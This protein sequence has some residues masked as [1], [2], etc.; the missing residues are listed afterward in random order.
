MLPKNIIRILAVVFILLLITGCSNIHQVNVSDKTAEEALK[1]AKE[2]EGS[3]YKWGGRG[4]NKFDCSGLITWSFKQALS[5]DYIFRVGNHVS[6][7]ATMEDLYNWNVSI[8]PIEKI[9]KGDIVFIT[10]KENHITHGGLFIEWIDKNTFKFINASSYHEK[11][12]IDEWSI[13][14]KKRGQ[15]FVGAGRLKI[16]YR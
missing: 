1:I 10:N 15:W 13:S 4:P 5:K 8:L 16:S 6:D 12:V 9:K 14:E 3:S 11:V 2:K 7:D